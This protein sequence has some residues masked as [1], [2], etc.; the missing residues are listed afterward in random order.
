MHNPPPQCLPQYLITT[1]LLPSATGLKHKSATIVLIHQHTVKRISAA[2][3]Q[4]TTFA[5][6]AL[7]EKDRVDSNEGHDA[8]TLIEVPGNYATGD[9]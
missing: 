5:N 6:T 1:P 2:C 7:D 3:H 4:L 8:S 9:S